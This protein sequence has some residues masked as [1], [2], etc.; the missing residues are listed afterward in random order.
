V[1]KL[2]ASG[3]PNAQAKAPNAQAKAPNAHQVF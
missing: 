2:T 3:A 1:E